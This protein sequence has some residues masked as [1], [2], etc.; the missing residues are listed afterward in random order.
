MAGVAMKFS[1]PLELPGGARWR[2]RNR[3]LP[4]HF[5]IISDRERTAGQIALHFAAA[6]AREK[7][8]L[9]LRLDA[10]GQDR[11]AE[12]AAETNDGTNDRGRLMI[13]PQVGNEGAVDLYLVER[14]R[15]QI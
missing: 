9:G 4:H 7:C 14:E 11:N 5:G 13:A 3:F 10:F 6:F 12:T 2:R 15:S 1:E 8:V